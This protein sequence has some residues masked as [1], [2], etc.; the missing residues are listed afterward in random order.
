MVDLNFIIKLR[1]SNPS[2]LELCMDVAGGDIN[3]PGTPVQAWECNA[4][5]A[6]NQNWQLDFNPH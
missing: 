3:T 1:K 4:E 5:Y 6:D 2:G